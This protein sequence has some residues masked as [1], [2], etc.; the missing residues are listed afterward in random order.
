MKQLV[1]VT[2]LAIFAMNEHSNG[3]VTT[4]KDSIKP[5]INFLENN[6]FLS[7]KDYILSKFETYD[8]VIISERHHADMTQYEVILDVVKDNRFNGNI[9]TEDCYK[10]SID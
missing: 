4:K 9:Y 8:I 2:L 10:Q 5:Y 6:N 7:A 3:Q 1:L